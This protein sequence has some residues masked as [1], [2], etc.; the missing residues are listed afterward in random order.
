MSG[1]AFDFW[2]NSNLRHAP[3][4]INTVCEIFHVSL[5]V[6]LVGVKLNFVHLLDMIGIESIGIYL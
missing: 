1:M 4:F 3:I 5:K 6:N 2:C